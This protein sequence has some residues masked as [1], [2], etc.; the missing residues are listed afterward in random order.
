MATKVKRIEP[1]EIDDISRGTSVMIPII[2]KKDNDT[3]LD[4]TGYELVFTLKAQQSDFDYDD[5][6]ALITKTFQPAPEMGRFNVCLTSKETWL[7]PGVYYFDLMLSRNQG[8]T[9][10]AIFKV[11]I[12][13]GPT[14]RLTNHSQDQ[15]FTTLYDALEVTPTN[16]GYVVIQVPLCPDPPPSILERAAGTPGYIFQGWGEPVNEIAY[17]N[18]GPRLSMMMT[19]RVQHDALPHRF[20]FDTFFHGN[21]IP[22]PC[23][24]A[25]GYIEFKNRLVTFHLNKEMAMLWYNTSVQHSPETTFDG[26]TGIQPSTQPIMVGDNVD[27]GEL[28]VQFVHKNDQ[29]HLT[30][31]HF[32]PDDAGGFEW[33]MIRIDWFNWNDPYEP[34]PERPDVSTS[35]P[36]QN[37][38]P[39]TWGG[40]WPP[41]MWY[42]EGDEKAD[43]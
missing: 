20:R 36:E 42:C 12:V 24:L 40:Y 16:Q 21:H 29:I 6:R 1:V 23:P 33:W 18:F 11:A 25:N 8:C 15:E 13:G 3:I 5:D 43:Y 34:D 39:D 27:A 10:L 37:P 32:M 41:D 31:H 17:T 28:T 38:Y 14:N 19:L 22:Y 2:L 35:F 26:N 7:E 9:R 4:V 30:A